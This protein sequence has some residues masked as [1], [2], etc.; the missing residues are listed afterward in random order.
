MLPPLLPRRVFI[1]YRHE[2]CA[3]YA[4]LL[5]ERLDRRFPNAI[6]VDLDSIGLGEDFVR[7]IDE[8]VSSCGVLVALI[9]RNWISVK[10]ANG[11]RLDNP[12]D[13][14]RLEIATALKRGIC[15]IPALLN[16]APIP[17]A[18][19]L[20]EDLA[21]LSTRR[22]L[23]ISDENLDYNVSQLSE[24]VEREFSQHGAG[25]N[26]VA[27]TTTA[28]NDRA[29]SVPPR[30]RWRNLLDLL[31]NPKP[32]SQVILTLV[33]I[34]VCALAQFLGSTH[35]INHFL[36]HQ[37]GFQV[38]K[39]IAIA[40]L[41]LTIAAYGFGFTSL[42][43]ARPKL[44][45]FWL[46]SALL[47]CFTA[48][49][50]ANLMFKPWPKLDALLKRE[51]SVWVDRIFENQDESGG[52]R[53]DLRSPNSSTGVWT[54][55]QCL[56]GVLL[57]RELAKQHADQVRAAFHYIEQNRHKKP[58][59]PED[60]WG[61]TLGAPRT[62]TEISAWVAL[63]YLQSFQDEIWDDKQKA[64]VLSNIERELRLIGDRQDPSGGWTP[65]LQKGPSLTRTYSTLMAV[66]SYV[67]AGKIPALRERLGPQ[68]ETRLRNGVQWLLNT[69]QRDDGWLPN[70]NRKG[71][72]EQ[73]PGLTAHVLFV[74]SLAEAENPSLASEGVLKEAKSAFLKQRNLVNFPVGSDTAV[75]SGD[76]HLTDE[77]TAEGMQ[78]LWYPWAVSAYKGLSDDLTLTQRERN[79]A[80]D[81]LEQML[82][83]FDE[84]SHRLEAG[85]TFMLAE[86]L[87]GVSEAST[88]SSAP[89]QP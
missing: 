1:S 48:A 69:Y 66:W 83:R 70:P 81:D 62:V 7:K 49:V 6:F 68:Y 5:Y 10:D 43:T 18:E 16:D 54:T 71:Q 73:F 34:A 55:A 39:D 25:N 4:K 3:A 84:V 44:H 2:N 60:G 14:V 76:V 23:R 88:V 15:V 85:Q 9:D 22:A 28:G 61:Y 30:S 63:A 19:Q 78:F 56:E 77:F 12:K 40:L 51:V 33:A 45:K 50:F 27:R 13:F 31:S 65:I 79:A 21:P 37:F 80:K 89:Q 17:A 86:N 52:I 29:E 35:N 46:V 82:S 24:A 47:A 53:E 38:A 64:E 58:N 59:Q 57:N 26:A 11:R 67:E 75:P 41:V 8:A 36:L 20:P 42:Y 32:K 87:V 74:L 72:E